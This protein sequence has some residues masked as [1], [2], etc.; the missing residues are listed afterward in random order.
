MALFPSVPFRL[1]WPLGGRQL[2][3]LAKRMNAIEM[4]VDG[5]AILD[6]NGAYTYMNAAHARCY[7]FEPHELTGKQW[8]I[9]YDAAKAARFRTE[10]FPALERDGAWSGQS[11][12]RRK[13][14]TEFHQDI[15]LRKLDDGGLI[16][17]VRDISDKIRNDHITKVV[18]LAVEA[19]ADGI[20]ITDE[21]NKIL[22]MN[23]SF[24]KIHGY[25]PHEREKYIGT[26]WRHLYNEAGQE[27]INSVVLPTAILKGA[28]SGSTVVVRPDGSRFYADASLT[29]LSDGLMLG[30]MRDISDRRAAEMERENLREKLFQS[31]KIEAVGRITTRLLD[32]FQAMLSVIRDVAGGKIGSPDEAMEKIRGAADKAQEGV[33]EIASFYGK[34]AVRAVPINLGDFITAQR[35]E[36]FSLFPKSISFEIDIKAPDLRAVFDEG[37]LRQII[38]NLCLNA[39]EA[40]ATPVGRVVLTVR[41]MDRNFLGLRREIITESVPDRTKAAG[42]RTKFPSE[43]KGYAISGYLLRDGAYAEIIVSDTG[44]GMSRDI[45]GNIFN[46]FFTTKALSRGAGLGLSTVQGYV[47]GGGGAV[48]VETVQDQGTDV[49]FYLPVADSPA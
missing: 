31:Q 47:A 38:R 6:A 45:L 46:P 41:V 25:N 26:D 18:K 48:I 8:S 10:I 20:A 5:I 7:G 34:K 35:S 40:I 1:T 11:E 3:F 16:C 12:G 39:I 42:V 30:V 21:D 15:S 29:K 27:H 17:V 28:W 13:D 32:D 33:D 19:A 23:L 49:H 36:L 14:G 44:R 9:L 22:F 2:Q 43:G 4:S 37:Q 24:L